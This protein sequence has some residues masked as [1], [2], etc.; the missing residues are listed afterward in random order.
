MFRSNWGIIIKESFN[1]GCCFLLVAVVFKL[2]PVICT[3]RK[4][5]GD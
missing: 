5:A 3:V 1:Y 4:E 2:D